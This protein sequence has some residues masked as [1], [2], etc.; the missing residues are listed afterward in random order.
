MPYWQMGPPRGSR[1]NPVQRKNGS[2]NI[3]KGEGSL[4]LY[5]SSVLDRKAKG[6]ER[7]GMYAVDQELL[8]PRP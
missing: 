5:G 8:N 4:G 2:L 6:W 7:L 1:R 3:G